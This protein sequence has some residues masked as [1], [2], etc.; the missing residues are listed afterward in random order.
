[1]DSSNKKD[2]KKNVDEDQLILS[3]M[4]ENEKMKDTYYTIERSLDDK[5]KKIIAELS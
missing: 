2:I 4:M 3:F 1:M 5:K